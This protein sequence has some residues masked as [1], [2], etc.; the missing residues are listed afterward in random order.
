MVRTGDDQRMFS[1]VTDLDLLRQKIIEVGNVR[2]V[3]IDPITAYLG[4]GK[5]DSFR[6]TDVRAVIAPLVELA[7]AAPASNHL[8][9]YMLPYTRFAVVC[10]DDKFV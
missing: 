3:Q 1:L 2:V 10:H 5:I 8:G 6:T 4:H 7:A 9:Y